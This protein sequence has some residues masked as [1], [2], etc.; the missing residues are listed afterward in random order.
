MVKLPF[1]MNII[2][3]HSLTSFTATT[4]AAAER[5]S[6]LVQLHH[7]CVNE[8]DS[9]SDFHVGAFAGRHRQVSS[10]AIVKMIRPCKLKSTALFVAFCDCV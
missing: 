9:S 7:D 2:C 6:Y 3:L 5:N 1:T 10:F 4:A 8:M